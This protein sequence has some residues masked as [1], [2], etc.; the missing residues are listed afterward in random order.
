MVKYLE[1]HWIC[2]KCKEKILE[3][4][5]FCKHC[6]ESID[7]DTETTWMCNKCEEEVSEMDKFCKTCGNS[8]STKMLDDPTEKKEIKRELKNDFDI[9]SILFIITLGVVLFFAYARIENFSETKFVETKSERQENL[10]TFFKDNYPNVPLPS[11]ERSTYQPVYTPEPYGKLIID[12][13]ARDLDNFHQKGWQD[14]FEGNE[15]DCSRMSTY[16]WDYIRTEYKI[17]PKIL[18]SNE[19]KHAWIAL[20]I[21]DTGDTD[22]YEQWTINGVKYY[23]LESTYPNIVKNI[24]N[25]KM[26]NDIFTSSTDFYTTTIYL[27]DNPQEANDVAG[28][29]SREFRLI[30]SDLDK[31]NVFNQ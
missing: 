4:D 9:N 31:L 18:I 19:R 26:G 29:W 2:D 28:K 15:F 17:P 21:S 30:K 1:N 16:M 12:N 27:A 3:T 14:L 24:P 5:K 23:F 22:R 20:R 10:N 13:I 6:G 8:V 7:I 11:E 25:Y